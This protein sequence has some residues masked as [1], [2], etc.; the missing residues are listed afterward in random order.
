VSL[1]V[2]DRGAWVATYRYIHVTLMEM[3]ARWVPTTPEMEVKLV[4]GSHI[5]Y[6]AQHADALGKRTHEL[7]LALQHSIP[8]VKEYLG[9]LDELGRVT[10]TSKRIAGMYDVMLPALGVRL[11]SY[12]ERTDQL[13]DAPTVRIVER[14]LDEDQRMIREGRGLREELPAVGSVDGTWVRRLAATESTVSDPVAPVAAV[15]S[16]VREAS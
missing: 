9:F 16:A 2:K 5:W 10:E 4:F 3:L 13:M 11:R 12:L 7:R 14:I 6:L 8:P 1:S 15:A